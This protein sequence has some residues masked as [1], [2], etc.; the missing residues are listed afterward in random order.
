MPK[1]S[2]PDLTGKVCIITGANTGIG[3]VTARELVAAGA[4]VFL[5]CRS[6]ERAEAAAARIAEATGKDAP[7]ILPLDLGSYESVRA[8]VDLF[9]GLNKPLH[10]LINN[11]GLAALHGQTS[12][13]F[14]MAFGVNHLG[15]FLLTHLLEEKIIETAKDG[16]PGRI[17]TV[18]SRA[19]FK[20][21]KG[22]DWAAVQERTKTTS[23]FPEYCVSKLANVLFS[24]KLA[25]RLK[26]K[27]VLCY[28]LHPG[29]VA[30]DVW[31]RVPAPI[32]FIMKLF[33]ITNE[34]GAMTTL[35]CATSSDCASQTGLYYDK[36]APM[37]ASTLGRD[38]ALA[39]ELWERS[40]EWT[41]LSAD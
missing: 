25:E 4:E 15:H 22:L 34:E 26:D 7:A 16:D 18:A 39:E 19:H 14:E 30:S 12:E 24:A 9:L 21:K 36:C 5:A 8:C 2:V 17:V 23:G 28:A 29:V 41:G 32:R 6:A 33:M 20:A 1:H 27:N 35:H 3:E 13:G 10:M 38:M 31:R 40:V 11:A 37:K